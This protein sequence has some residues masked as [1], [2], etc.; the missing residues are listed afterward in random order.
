MAGLLL[1]VSLV[2]G[3][4]VNAESSPRAL[5]VT[6]GPF[7]RLNASPTP[8]PTGVGH[9]LIYLVQDGALVA[10]TRR[11]PT[12]PQPQDVLQA[13][14]A[15]PSGRESAAGL[16]T[17]VP[18]DV[19]VQSTKGAVVQLLLA[20]SAAP[21][22]QRSDEVLG[23]AQLVVTLTGLRGVSAVEFVRDG[24]VLAVPRADGQLSTAPLTRKD[25]L[26][27]L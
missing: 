22:A 1:M 7:E 24:H 15:G 12:Q 20:G 18:A 16:T 14:L 27:L 9:A 26:T 3:C 5:S 4:G 13:L 21:D 23:L 2:T 25:Y 11:V 19:T 10:V 6:S 8:A 17:A